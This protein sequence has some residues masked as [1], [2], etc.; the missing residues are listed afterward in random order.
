MVVHHAKGGRY[1]FDRGDWITDMYGCRQRRAFENNAAIGHCGHFM[2]LYSV[3][4]WCNHTTAA[5]TGGNMTRV[6]TMLIML[7]VLITPVGAM[8]F[9]APSAPS[10][11][12]DLVPIEPENF[13]DGLWEV[14]KSAFQN[15]QPDIVQASKTCVA[16]LAV[17]LLA[18]LLKSMP[19]NSKHVMKFVSVLAVGSIL[20]GQ[21]NNMVT[22][23]ADTVQELSE[24]GKLLLP[25]M[26]GALAAQGGT[27]GASALYVGTAF[28]DTFLGSLIGRLLVPMVYLYL[29]L[30]IANA[31][32]GEELL[33]KIRDLLKWLMTWGLKTILY[34]FTGYMSIT[35]VIAGTADAAAIKAAKLAISG[36]VPVV[37]GILSDASEAVVLSAGVMKSTVGIY[38]LLVIAAIWITPFLTIG[39]QY[40]MLKLTAAVCAVFGVKEASELIENFSGAMGLLL[41]MT[42]AMSFLLLVSAICFMKGMG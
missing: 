40:L 32:T 12:E 28:F 30:A 6:L 27:T 25:V 21:T 17:V 22:L 3:N 37:G 19:G 23:C 16:L 18:S 36:A 38:G 15:L 13:G 33:K 26:T 42:G 1:W 10:H 5:D 2:A 34:I 39:I 35:G 29:A 24:Y 4:E 14:V 20:L 7:S 8:E 9:T 31:I 41:G 11:V